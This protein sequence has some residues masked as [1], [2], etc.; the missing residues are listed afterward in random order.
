[1]AKV[2][3]FCDGNIE[4]GIKYISSE[5]EILGYPEIYYEQQSDRQVLINLV[6]TTW[7]LITDMKTLLLK[8]NEHTVEIIKLKSQITLHINEKSNF[9]KLLDKE[10]NSFATLNESYKSA[11]SQRNNLNKE[12]KKTKLDL[13]NIKKSMNSVEL[14]FG[15]EILR[16]KNIIS[17]LKDKLARFVNEDCTDIEETTFPQFSS[18]KVKFPKLD[19]Y[20]SFLCNNIQILI[21]ENA[22]IRNLIIKILVQ[23]SNK[24]NSKCTIDE[25]E[26]THY[27][28]NLTEQGFLEKIEEKFNNLL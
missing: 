11:L 1:M 23:L 21:L 20:L 12:L 27:L 6:N 4:L 19:K 13:K 9:E 8:N 28:L 25:N 22:T 7:A 15:N 14:Q 16:Q 3:D 17:Q 10:R 26:L 5:L 2:N 24:R 18:V